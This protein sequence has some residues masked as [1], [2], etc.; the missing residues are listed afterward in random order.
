[1]T[2]LVNGKLYVFS[3]FGFEIKIL[4]TTTM[5]DPATDSWTEKAPIPIPV[6]HTGAIVSGNEIWLAGGFEGDNPGV[7][8]NSVQVYNIVTD[9]WRFGPSLPEKRASAAMALVG[10]KLHFFGGLKED[11]QTDVSE[12]YVLDLDNESKG[13]TKAA[14]LPEARN[15]LSA[16]AV[17]GLIYAIGGQK[18]HDKSIENTAFLHAYDPVTDKWERKADLTFARSHFEPATF[19]LDGE[20][21]IVGGRTEF[22]FFKEITKYS[23]ETNTWTEVCGLP[24]K[25]LA[26]AARVINNHLYVTHGGASNVRNPLN[27]VYKR[28]VDRKFSADM[29]FLRASLSLS[30]S[31]GSQKTIEEAVWVKSNTPKYNLSVD[32]SPSWIKATAFS[33]QASHE[34]DQV[35]ITIDARGLEAGSYNTVLKAS[36]SGYATAELPISITVTGNS[37]AEAIF[38]NTGG[39]ETTTIN[40]L[41]Y[42][43]DSNAPS[44]YDSEHTYTNTALSNVLY[45]TERGSST[46]KGSLTYN[47]PVSNGKYT[48]RTHHAELYFGYKKPNA[49]GNRVFDI[50]LEGQLVK[51]KVDLFEEGVGPEQSL[52]AKVFTFEEVEVTDGKLTLSMSASVN[53]PTLSALE[54]IPENVTAPSDEIWLEAE[55]AVVGSNWQVGEDEDASGNQYVTIKPGKNSYG[56]APEGKANHV[57]FDFNVGQ[58]GTY[59]IFARV[60]APSYGD[61]SFWVKI[62]EGTWINWSKNI[63]TGEFAWKEI[64]ESPFALQAGANTIT[65]AYREDGALLD[66]IRIVSTALLPPSST[67]IWLESECASAI[68]ENWQIGEDED[69][70]GNQYVTIKPGKNSYGQAPEGKA[71]HV[72]FNFN[73]GQVGTYQ[74]FARV[75]ASNSTKDSFWFKVNDAEWINWS[76]NVQTYAFAWKE[77]VESPFSLQAGTNTITFAYR[78][79][80]TQLDKIFI[81]LNGD[82]PEGMGESAIKCSGNEDN[83]RIAKSIQKGKSISDELEVIEQSNSTEFLVFPNPTTKEVKIQL[84]EQ[85]K[86]GSIL[87]LYD[88]KGVIQQQIQVTDHNMLLD[89]KQLPAGMYYVQYND[90][91]NSISRKLMVSK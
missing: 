60:K 33:G 28:P 20:I 3:G 64:V 55:Q 75:K 82:Q 46:D 89:V 78:E 67:D 76:E 5:Y 19:V 51:E 59:Q 29:G 40:A 10:R 71:N 16:V 80:G 22:Q 86:K 41:T 37:P 36:A 53:R 34:G 44:Y 21:Y 90:G 62:N 18:G 65:F 7:A 81:T 54:I 61:D 4:S 73:V 17:G 27:T 14:P 32:G 63:H 43:S 11:R 83:T 84:G 9:E 57:S 50:S 87:Y 72:S 45:Q 26:P 66:Q 47:I 15:H 8:I 23:P 2:A 38:L 35:K 31:P 1:M 13:W 79:D 25:L 52:E 68:G 12:H 70:S 30:L 77:I 48:V 6:T 74:I 56:Q 85:F 49:P 69:A 91:K 24:L 42:E 58:A 39:G 88:S